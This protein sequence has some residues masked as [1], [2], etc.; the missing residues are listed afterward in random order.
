MRTS[1]GTSSVNVDGALLD[2]DSLV[3]RI[4]PETKREFEGVSRRAWRMADSDWPRRSGDSYR[5]V[6]VTTRLTPKH[7]ETVV[8]N[9]ERYA[10]FMKWSR[11][12]RTEIHQ[13]SNTDKQRR[14][15]EKRHGKG[16]PRDAWIEKRPWLE[17]LGKPIRK[18]EDGLADRLERELFRLSNRGA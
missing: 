17:L 8:S 16:A 6:R 14:F 3:D 4:S 15:L 1:D 10:Y 18:S 2:M 12:T 13:R 5:G 9:V 11:Y 7:I